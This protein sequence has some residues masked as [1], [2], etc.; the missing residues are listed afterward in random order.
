MTKLR[1]L[2]VDDHDN[3]AH[4]VCKLIDLLGH[5]CVVATTGRE[6]ITRAAELKPHLAI[7]DIG[8]PDMSGYDVARALRAQARLAGLVLAA[9]TGWGDDADRRRAFAAGFDQHITKPLDVGKLRDVLDYAQRSPGAVRV[10]DVI[11]SHQRR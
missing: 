8:L 1:V 9:L 10:E 6:A 11:S 7:I 2:V 5:T 4:A 3:A